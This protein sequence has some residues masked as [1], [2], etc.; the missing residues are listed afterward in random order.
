MANIT[1]PAM[2]DSTG[3][4]IV[5]KLNIIADRIKPTGGGGTGTDDYT[6]LTNK[7]SIESVTLTGN[8][9]ASDLGL[10]TALLWDTIPVK[11]SVK[12]VNSGGIYSAIN[13][14]VSQESSARQL[15]DD[16]LQA[17]INNIKEVSAGQAAKDWE[18]VFGSAGTNPDANVQMASADSNID[19]SDVV[20]EG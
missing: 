11:N 3:Q 1:N 14:A 10:Q 8:K 13:T 17:A 16:Q 18:D 9:T 6:D 5:D 2:L 12:A 20:Y 19:S 4:S 15:I 7:P